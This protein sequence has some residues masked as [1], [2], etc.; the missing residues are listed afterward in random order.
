MSVVFF[1]VA[2]LV[3]LSAMLGGLLRKRAHDRA[4]GPTPAVVLVGRHRT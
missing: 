3:V 4:G 1:T 2:Q